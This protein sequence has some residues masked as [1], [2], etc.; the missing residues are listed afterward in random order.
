[1]WPETIIENIEVIK[2]WGIYTWTY[3][4]QIDIRQ[5]DITWRIFIKQSDLLKM[6]WKANE[7]KEEKIELDDNIAFV[8]SLIRW[9]SKWE[10]IVDEKPLSLE[11]LKK[12]CDF[13]KEKRKD[14]K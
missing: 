1:M 9:D 14:L 5:W 12:H 2:A 4:Y 11:E 8:E 7:R 3:H 10:C 6:L 13:L